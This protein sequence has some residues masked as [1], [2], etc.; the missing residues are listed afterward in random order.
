MSAS[1]AFKLHHSFRLLWLGDP[2]RYLA[3]LH[4]LTNETYN[5]TGIV[6]SSVALDWVMATSARATMW[7]LIGNT[8]QGRG[9]FRRPLDKTCCCGV[10]SCLED[11]FT[12]W[13]TLGSRFR[14][15]FNSS[16]SKVF[17]YLFL[18]I[19]GTLACTCPLCSSMVATC[20]GPTPNYNWCF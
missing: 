8:L 1:L 15:C 10:G 2:W 16:V 11:R 14:L 17:L 19:C 6:W 9:K 7:A 4:E 18:A 12:T 20:C 5:G 13:H 3:R